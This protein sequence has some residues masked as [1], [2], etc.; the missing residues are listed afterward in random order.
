MLLVVDI[1][2][3]GSKD[4][5]IKRWNVYL[6]KLTVIKTEALK[7]CLSMPSSTMTPNTLICTHTQVGHDKDINAISVSP[8]D[9]LVATGSEDKTI[10]VGSEDT[11]VVRIVRVPQ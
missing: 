3:T 2:V 4:T 9:R 10:K 8:K 6:E 1:L 7:K 5:C 11:P